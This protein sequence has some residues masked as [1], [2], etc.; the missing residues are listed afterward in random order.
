MG[1]CVCA[2]PGCGDGCVGAERVVVAGRGVDVCWLGTTDGGAAVG[3]AVLAAVVV[4]GCAVG[5]V[6]AAGADGEAV[7][8]RG[9]VVVGVVVGMSVAV[10]GD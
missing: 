5:A 4:V 1:L 8:G 2:G 7:C 3:P 9:L 10:V 6:R